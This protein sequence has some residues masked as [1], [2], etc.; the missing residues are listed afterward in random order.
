MKYTCIHVFSEGVG[1]KKVNIGCSAH[2]GYSAPNSGDGSGA[3]HPMFT[4][5]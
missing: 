3:L 4:V 1:P 2:I 5:L